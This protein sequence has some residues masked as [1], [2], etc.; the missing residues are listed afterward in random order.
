LNRF[1]FL[2]KLSSPVATQAAENLQIH[3]PAVTK[4]LQLLE[5]H[6]GTRLCKRTTRRINL[7]PDGEA[8]YRQ[9]KPL[10]AQ[11]DALLESFGSDSRYTASFTWI[12]PSLLRRYWCPPSA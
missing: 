2:L 7:T 12:C 9:S 6:C 5:Q 4:A 1:A 8:F 11:A 3:R 10:L